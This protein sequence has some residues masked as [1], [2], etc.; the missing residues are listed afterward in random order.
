M[1]RFRLQV[2]Y[3]G[4]A[5]HG[6]QYQP[7]V[8]TVAGELRR[9]IAELVGH[10]VDVMGASRT[11]AGVHARAQCAAFD[12]DTDRT[13][14]AVYRAVNHRTPSDIAVRR[15]EEVDVGFHP[16][17]DSRGKIYVYRIG[18]G[19]HADPFERGR[20]MHVRSRLDVDAMARAG[21]YLVGEHDFSSF[22]ASGCDAMTAVRMI[23]HVGVRRAGGCVEVEV[24][25]SAFLKYMVRIIVGTLVEVGRGRREPAWVADVLAGRDRRLAG[26]TAEPQG[27]TLERIFYPDRPWGR[28]PMVVR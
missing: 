2:A 10:D 13:A 26:P 25:G 17:H 6:W 16:R 7:D 11:D 15:V 14:E 19:W 1:R 3:V 20:T 4:T 12:T 9:A 5:Y 24:A 21:S 18:Q 28:A 23:W 22:R 27:L 8:P